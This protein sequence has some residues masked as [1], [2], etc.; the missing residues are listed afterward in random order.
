MQIAPHVQG[1]VETLSQI[2]PL[3]GFFFSGTVPLTAELFTH[4][5][6]NV[7]Q[8]RQVLQI[9]LWKLKALRQWDT[10]AITAYINETGE[11]LEM[12][13]RDMMPLMFAA[14]TGQASS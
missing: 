6:L 10:E 7:D 14:I 1:R 8:V 2:A 11:L 3:A 12:K 5:K 9:T 4:K 13:L